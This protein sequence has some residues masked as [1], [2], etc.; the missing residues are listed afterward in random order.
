MRKRINKIDG[1]SDM[2]GETI[3]NFLFGYFTAIVSYGFWQ[4]NM[5]QE[6]YMQLVQN[7][8]VQINP[9]TWLLIWVVGLVLYSLTKITTNTDKTENNKG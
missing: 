3:K 7:N 5:G 6:K 2:K 9:S 4:D 1:E 8:W